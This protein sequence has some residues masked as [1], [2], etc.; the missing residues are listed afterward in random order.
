VS[1]ITREQRSGA[2]A[3]PSFHPVIAP[4][5]RKELVD[6][7]ERLE[8]ACDVRDVRSDRGR[9]LRPAALPRDRRTAYVS[10]R[11]NSLLGAAPAPGRP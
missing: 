8:R 9:S 4:L 5:E 1:G 7:G 3:P 6:R 11:Q 10:P 2:T